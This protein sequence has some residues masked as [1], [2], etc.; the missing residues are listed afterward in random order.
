MDALIFVQ[1]PEVNIATNTFIDVPVI[2]QYEDTPLIEVTKLE[3][4]GFTI[5]IPIYHPDGTYLAKV[6]GSRLFT[7]E[8]GKKAGLNLKYP[9]NMTICEL[10][11]KTLFEIHRVGAA[12]LKAKAE[13]Y[14]PDGAFVKCSHDLMPQLFLGDNEK[15]LKIGGIVMSGNVFRGFRIG[16]L[17]RKD[18]GLSIGVS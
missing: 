4:A 15:P 18:G 14:T 11:G 7:T 3:K 1:T 6:V 13:L 12:A 2:L 10:E 8:D 5:Q 16:I 9:K 17:I